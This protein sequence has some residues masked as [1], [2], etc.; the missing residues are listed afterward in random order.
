MALGVNASWNC[1]SD[2]IHL[3]GSGEHQRADFDGADSAF[4]VEFRGEGYAG[5]LIGCDVREEGSCIDIDGVAAGRLDNWDSAGGD[6]VAQV[7]GGGDAISEVVFLESFLDSDGDSFEIAAGETSVGWIAFG[8]D[9]EIFSCWARM[10]LL[11]QRNPPML[12]IPSFLADM[13]QPSP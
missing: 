6:V 13:V 7:G 12:A 2:E 1:Q 3:G 4:E 11:V 9:E 10:S 8:E 5:E